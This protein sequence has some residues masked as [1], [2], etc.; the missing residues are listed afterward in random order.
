MKHFEPV[1]GNV[2]LLRLCAADDPPSNDQK[3]RLEI[4]R[5]SMNVSDVAIRC[6]SLRII[7]PR[8]ANEDGLAG[9]LRDDPFCP[10]AGPPARPAA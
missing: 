7:P 4:C 6:F 5:V 2:I 10:D 8:R 9:P 3:T 1:A